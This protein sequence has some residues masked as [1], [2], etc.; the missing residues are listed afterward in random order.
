MSS[1]GTKTSTQRTADLVLAILS[2]A[3]FNEGKANPMS[4]SFLQEAFESLSRKAPTYRSIFSFR[5]TTKGPYSQELQ[6]ALMALPTE[7]FQDLH[8]KDCL[9]VPSDIAMRNLV[10]LRQEYG[11]D[12]VDGPMTQISEV[13]VQCLPTT[14]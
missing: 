3:S 2:L 12:F 5:Q 6:D 8:A 7:L 14:H 9:Q 4:L 13:F 1:V 10:R 11:D